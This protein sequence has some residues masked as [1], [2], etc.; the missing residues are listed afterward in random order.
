VEAGLAESVDIERWSA[1]F[2]RAD[3]RRD[4]PIRFS[5]VF[6]GVGRAPA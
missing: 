4:R 1:A 6:V 2:E 5:P 3:G